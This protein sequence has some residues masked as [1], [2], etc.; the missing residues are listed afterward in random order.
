MRFR[1]WAA[2]LVLLGGCSY[3]NVA[4]NDTALPLES[5]VHN[6]TRA[7]TFTAVAAPQGNSSEATDPTRREMTATN[8][9][10][11]AQAGQMRDHDGYFVGL[12]ISGGGSRSANFAAACMFQ[13]EREGMLQKVDYISSVSGGSLTAAYYCTSRD[14]WNPKNVQ[15]KLTHPFASD[16][17]VQTLLPWNVFALLFTDYDRSDLLAKTLNE[18]LFSPDGRQQTYAD[19]RPDR[20]RLLVNATDLQT[21]RR[22]VFCNETFD[23]LN[24]DLSKLPIAYAVAASSSVPVVLHDVTLRDFSTEFKQYRHLV[25]GGVADN[26]G[27]ETL[28][29]T[30]RAQVESAAKHNLPDPYPHGAVFI[31]LD[32]RTE[33]DQNLANES[34]TGVV[35]AIAASTGLTTR[36]LLNRASSTTLDDVILKNA[37]D[38]ATIKEVRDSVKDLEQ[39]GYADFPNLGGHRI[40]VV[41]I[42]LTQLGSL[43]QLPFNSFQESVNSTGTYFNITPEKAA[44]LYVAADL[45]FRDRYDAHFKAL[46]EKMNRG[47]SD[48]TTRPTTEP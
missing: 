31:V 11:V 23:R 42:A 48:A 38:T 8:N 17:L 10:A 28:V 40:R 47:E 19:L 12:A 21:G 5:R 22:F 36:L 25:D 20:P 29:E 2:A 44:E 24:S 26:L 39:N 35:D 43:R 33:Y 9:P 7:A 13:L 46:L 15:E 34:D 16:M 30:Y 1:S 14:G 27:V 45:L 32:A 6:H 41:H 18:N 3:P 37:P 4:L